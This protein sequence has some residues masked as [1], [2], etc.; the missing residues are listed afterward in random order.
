MADN[1]IRLNVSAVESE[2]LN[3]CVEQVPMNPVN[4]ENTYKGL[5]YN[6]LK[7]KPSIDGV[8][9]EGDKTTAE[10]IGFDKEYV[11]DAILAT[12]AKIDSI[13]Q[14]LIDRIDDVYARE[15]YSK[16]EIDNKVIVIEADIDAQ[17]DAI[18]K[19]RSDFMESDSELQQQ[20]NAHAEELTTQKNDIDELG[21][22]VAGIESKIPEGTSDTNPLINRQQ[23][24]DEEMDI[25]S[26]FNE[27]VSELQTQITA[28]ASAIA[29][30]VD[31]T[32]DTMTGALNLPE[33]N[34]ATSEGTLNL[35]ITAGV[36]TIATNN[37]LD[38]VSQ[39]KFDTAP[40]T[41]DS[42]TWADALDTSLV[43]KAQVA[44]AIAEAGG[45]GTSGNAYT[46]ENLIG[47]KGVEIVPETTGGGKDE[48]TIALWHF[49]DTLTDGISGLEFYSASDKNPGFD[50]GKFGR[51]LKTVRGGDS[52]SILLSD[53]LFNDRNFKDI[54][55]T[56]D[57]WHDASYGGFYIATGSNS[58]Y[59][60]Y[61][62]FAVNFDSSYR[63]ISVKINNVEKTS[64][65]Y[66]F[67]QGGEYWHKAVQKEGNTLTVFLNG[68]P[69]LSYTLTEEDKAL[70]NY[71]GFY[72]SGGPKIDELRISDVARYSGKFTPP[73]EPYSE[74]VLTGRSFINNTA[75]KNI[76]EVFY[77]QSNS[78]TDNAGA[79]PL[80]TGETIANADAL[81]P[82]FFSWVSSHSELQ[83]TAE[84][85][86]AELLSRGDCNKYVV[87][88]TSVRLPKK[89]LDKRYLIESKYPTETDSSWYN[90]YSDGWIEQGGRVSSATENADFVVTLTKPMLNN[91]YCIQRT[92]ASASTTTATYRAVSVKG[93]TTTEFKMYITDTISPTYWYVCGQSSITPQDKVDYPWVQAYNY[94]VPAS[95]AQAA[96]FQSAL[97]GKADNNLGNIPANYDYVYR[98]FNQEAG[99][100]AAASWWRIYRSGWIEQGGTTGNA[101]NTET[102]TFAKPFARVPF[103]YCFCIAGDNY[104]KGVNVTSASATSFTF[105]KTTEGGTLIQNRINWFACG[106]GV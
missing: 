32:G 2:P 24:L 12:N 96:E 10:V 57:A 23:L 28:Q 35:S 59:A 98:T 64:V 74:P 52:G 106:Q 56:I 80:F 30:K 33:L 39:T 66:S 22:Q 68:E 3:V 78:A 89:T 77:S 55:F 7:N 85:Y 70:C 45:G 60:A 20:I 73:T 91:R 58:S 4:V 102:I 53:R 27:S 34:V 104:V 18:Q 84:E 87:D 36:A 40:T 62:G 11:D 44:T 79:L 61:N 26:D 47:G 38:I 49:E 14:D 67:S 6:L 50:V 5:D 37:G 63:K 43:R 15:G 9:L 48:N 76:G 16:E 31:V 69:M 95:S 101:T 105:K 65:P 19:T 71:N 82:D 83:T 94:A 46:K 100:T 92:S 54:D 17:A 99:T 42:T 86:E 29:N 21:D 103:I 41:D 97:S 72:I 81:Y 13:E 1:E 25:R 90:L 75:G 88:G 8:T 93:I 51:G